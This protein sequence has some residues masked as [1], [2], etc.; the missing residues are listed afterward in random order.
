LREWSSKGIR[1]GKSKLAREAEVDLI[2]MPT[3]GYGPF[4]RF[5]L[6]SVTAKVLHDTDIPV[7]TGA[8]VTDKPLDPLP[9]FR[10]VAAAVD[11]SAHSE[12][13]LRWAAGFAAAYQA[14]LALVHAAPSLAVSGQP[15]QYGGSEWRGV[16]IE[17]SRNEARRLMEMA[18]C[19]AEIFTDCAGVTEYV[20]AALAEAGAQ[21]LII[22]RS[23]HQ[24]LIGRLR[25]NAYALIRESPIPVVSV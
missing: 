7:Y 14:K 25:T 11:L 21:L 13:V 15:G 24:G 4:R 12:K 3:H 9:A 18:R 20:P 19:Q 8:H 17:R 2:V 6:G 23:V 22:G 10:T 5:I 16:L 1:R